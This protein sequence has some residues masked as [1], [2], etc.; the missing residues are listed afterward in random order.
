[1]HGGLVSDALHRL[2]VCHVSSL[3]VAAAPLEI[4]AL[5]HR[6]HPCGDDATCKFKKKTVKKTRKTAKKS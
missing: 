4:R 3:L 6:L 2:L 5:H 1:M